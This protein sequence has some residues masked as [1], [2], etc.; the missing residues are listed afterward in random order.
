MLEHFEKILNR[1]TGAAKDQIASVGKWLSAQGFPCPVLPAAL[2]SLLMESNGGLFTVCFREY[3]LFSTSELQEYYEV[4]QFNKY[5]PYALP[6]AMDGCGN[7]YLFNLRNKDCAVYAVSAGNLG[8]GPD[9]C[10]QIADSLEDCLRQVDPL[11]DLM[12]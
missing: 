12:H 4:Y 2:A 8:W 6:W 10:Y 5:M 11:D 1:N 9:E 7:F 3:Q